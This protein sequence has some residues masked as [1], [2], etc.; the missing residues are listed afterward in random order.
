[1]GGSKPAENKI[2]ETELSKEQ[3]KIVQAREQ[4]LQSYTIPELK[5]HLT[6]VKENQLRDDFKYTSNM[7]VLANQVSDIRDQFQVQRDQLS[8]NLAQRG[9]EQ[10]GVEA[11]S[12]MQ[13]ASAEASNVSGAVN[14]STLQDMLQKNGLI[15]LQN[16]NKLNQNQMYGSAIQNMLRLAPQPTTA[17]PQQMMK[18]P[19]KKSPWGATLGGGIQGAQI[20]GQAGGPWGAVIGGVVGSGSGYASAT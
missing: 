11:N 20:G 18:E 5:D 6:S 4:F 8:N 19:D 14:Q 3:T 13:L 10:S 12:L 17:A 2:K 16:Q 7:P 1:M 15:D 9:M